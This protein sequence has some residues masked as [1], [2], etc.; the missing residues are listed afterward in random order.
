MNLGDFRTKVIQKTKKFEGGVL[1]PQPSETTVLSDLIN[2]WL[3][4]FCVE[5]LAIY[6]SSCSVTLTIGQKDYDLRGTDFALPM[7]TVQRVTIGNAILMGTDGRPGPMDPAYLQRMYPTMAETDDARPQHW[8]MENYETLRLW[9]APS[10]EFDC[11]VQGYGV[12]A[13]MDSDDDLL[14]IPAVWLDVAAH[15][16]AC[17]WVDQASPTAVVA[18]ELQFVQQAVSVIAQDQVQKHSAASPRGFPRQRRV[19]FNG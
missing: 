6:R 16:C 18:P 4:D 7:A 2:K 3:K 15:Y 14:E 8:W 9:P 1:V 10:E 13:A 19:M 11:T 17:R 12:Q 5:S